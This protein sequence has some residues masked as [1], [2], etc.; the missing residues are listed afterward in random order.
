MS[1]DSAIVGPISFAI[2][3]LQNKKTVCVKAYTINGMY[4]MT[5]YTKYL[6]IPSK[7]LIRFSRLWTLKVEIWATLRAKAWSKLL[8]KTRCKEAMKQN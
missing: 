1:K 8:I 5:V 2:F 6:Y 3:C 4:A 7:F